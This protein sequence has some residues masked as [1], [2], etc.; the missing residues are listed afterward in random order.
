[1]FWSCAS[2]RDGDVTLR[3]AKLQSVDMSLLT[4]WRGKAALA[5]RAHSPVGADGLMRKVMPTTAAHV[6]KKM[7]FPLAGRQR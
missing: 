7:G 4:R 2:R 3:F 6:A 5:H 1:M